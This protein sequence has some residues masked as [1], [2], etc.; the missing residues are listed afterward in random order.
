[1]REKK[2]AIVTGA[3]SGIGA[4]IAVDLAQAGCHV[5]VNYSRNCDG[6]E[7]V[8]KSCCLA[9]VE[10][11]AVQGDIASD[12]NCRAMAKAALEAWGRI[13]VLVNNA[14][15]TRFADARD[16]DAL[17]RD[18]FEHIFA[19]NVAGCYQM[20]RAAASP[21]AE[22]GGSVVNI[23]SHS[24]FSGIGSSIA[25]A[26]SKGALNTMTL[27]LARSLAP[28][29]RVNAVCPGFVD[30][31]WMA[32]QL[33][34]DELAAFKRKTAALAPLQRIVTPEEVA[35]ATRWFALG[36]PSTTG[37]LLVIDGGTHLTVGA[38]F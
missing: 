15:V 6:G 12:V 14:G 8:A 16:L 19:V 30:T 24:G 20:T 5:L 7:A 13:D 38:P 22:T 25:Y 4:A 31:D 32:P 34:S 37:Q 11:I 10:A 27:S 26:A 33:S 23:S 28:R 2:V 35:E 9:G 1:M 21:L 3:S 17:Q 18:D 29:V 36:G